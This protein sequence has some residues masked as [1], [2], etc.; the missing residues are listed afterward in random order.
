M[1][2]VVRG[3]A[4]VAVGRIGPAGVDAQDLAVGEGPGLGNC[5]LETDSAVADGHIQL[6]EIRTPGR[7]EWVE[8]DLLDGVQEAGEPDAH[9]GAVGAAER[10]GGGVGGGPFGQDAVHHGARLGPVR[11][12]RGER[13]ERFAVRGVEAAVGGEVG[14]EGDEA[15]AAA[16]SFAGEE[17]RADGRP[18]VEVDA[19]GAAAERLGVQ[20][21]VE[22]RDEQPRLPRDL[23]EEVD[24]GAAHQPGVGRRRYRVGLRELRAE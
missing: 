4:V 15:E 19:R 18:N 20:P 12:A 23:A 10:G 9:E 14:V 17:V 22:I 7:G 24:P 21:A 6:A 11:G 2:G 16:H 1:N 13:V 8:V 5:V 3:N